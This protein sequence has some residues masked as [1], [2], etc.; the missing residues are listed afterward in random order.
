[1]SVH[2]DTIVSRKS[3][4]LCSSTSRSTLYNA[5]LESSCLLEKLLLGFTQKMQWPPDTADPWQ[6]GLLVSSR[7]NELLSSKLLSVPLGWW[8]IDSTTTLGEPGVR[9]KVQPGV[10][11]P[12]I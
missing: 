1:M 10:Y 8:Q 4:K 11:S 9:L 7:L 2:C 5:E 12:P 6:T 3:I